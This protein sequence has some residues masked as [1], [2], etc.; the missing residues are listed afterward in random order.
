MSEAH[1]IQSVHKDTLHISKI[2]MT[3]KCQELLDYQQ[4]ISPDL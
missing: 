1:I 4:T 3:A 2:K